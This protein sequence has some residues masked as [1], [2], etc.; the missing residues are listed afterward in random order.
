MTTG[1]PPRHE[2]VEQRLRAALEARSRTIDLGDLR[3]AEPP[4]MLARSHAPLRL[5]LA[6]VFGL[7]VVA[8]CVALVVAALPTSTV[9]VRVPPASTGTRSPGSPTSTR[10]PPG[11]VPASRS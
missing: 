9:P 6:V 8:L 5:T 2:A 10:T 4:T 7:A 3:P 11:P 1:T